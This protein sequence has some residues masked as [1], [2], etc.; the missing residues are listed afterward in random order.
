MNVQEQYGHGE[1]IS[2]IPVLIPYPSPHTKLPTGGA[3]R[4]PE[5]EETD[6]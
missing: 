5:P 4:N 1:S 6:G 2:R 3:V